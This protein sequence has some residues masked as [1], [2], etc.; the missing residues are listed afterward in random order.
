M[1]YHQYQE[2]NKENVKARTSRSRTRKDKRAL[3]RRVLTKSMFLLWRY[4]PDKVPMHKN[5]FP[6][7]RYANNDRHKGALSSM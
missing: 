1:P 5:R 6:T 4:L 7:L 2:W 3:W